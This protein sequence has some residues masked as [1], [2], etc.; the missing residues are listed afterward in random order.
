M[1]LE[2][3]KSPCILQHQCLSSEL[4]WFIHYDPDK[5]TPNV[6]VQCLHFARK[7]TQRD[8]EINLKWCKR[9]AKNFF[10]LPRPFLS[11]FM[12]LYPPPPTLS[13]TSWISRHSIVLLN[14]YEFEPNIFLTCALDT[15]IQYFQ[16]TIVFNFFTLIEFFIAQNWVLNDPTQFVLTLFLRKKQFYP[17]NNQKLLILI[18]SRHSKNRKWTFWNIEMIFL[19]HRLHSSIIENATSVHADH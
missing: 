15:F 1:T 4:S 16:F 17:E 12:L 8:F 7:M 18:F 13:S 14:S 3:F 19:L 11:K 6:R 10:Y 9:K 5:R 2:H